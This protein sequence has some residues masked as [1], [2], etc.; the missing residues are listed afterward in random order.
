MKKRILYIDVL[1]IAACLAVIFNHSGGFYLFGEQEP[2]G[3]WY[4]LDL[5]ASVCCKFAVP[6]FFAISGAMMLHRE[7]GLKKLYTGRILRIALALAVFSVIS[8]L[9]EAAQGRV[10]LSLRGMVFGLYDRNL[11]FS[12]WY[13][14][15]Y[16]AFLMISPM[17]GAMLRSLSDRQLLY[18]LALGLFFKA[19]LPAFELLRWAGAHSL[20]PDFDLSAVTSDIVLYPAMGYFVHH[21]M[22]LLDVRRWTPAALLAAAAGVAVCVEL[23]LTEYYRTWVPKVEPYTAAA[24]PLLGLAVMMAGRA[25]FGESEATGRSGAWVSC[26]AALSFGA[27]LLHIPV[28]HSDALVRAFGAF[29]E[30]APLPRMLEYAIEVLAVAAICGAMTAV[31]KRIPGIRRLI[32]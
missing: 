14:Y 15:A 3:L 25:V 5:V 17:L 21:R 30:A 29:S 2:G 19:V 11:N 18:M 1:R 23:T 9:V 12:Y 22:R 13:L 31:L 8:H 27:Y 7:I 28:L 6:V 24:M 26:L 4:R 20:S 16:L 32:S 10:T